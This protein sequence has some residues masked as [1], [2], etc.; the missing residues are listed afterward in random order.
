M[1]SLTLLGYL[2]DQF[3]QSVCNTRTDEYGGSIEN[4]ARFALEV[5]QAV[6]SAIGED[7]TGIRL[8]PWSEFGGKNILAV[9]Y[10]IS[11][12]S[13]LDM[14]EANPI[15]T[16]SY[17]IQQLYDRFPSLAYLHLVEPRIRG[18]NDTKGKEVDAGQEETNE[19]ARAIWKERPLI[20]AGGFDPRTAKEK[21]EKDG[22]LVAF[23]RWY[24]SNVS[25]FDSAFRRPFTS[26]S[27]PDLPE[28]IKRGAELIPYDRKSFYIPESPKGYID[29]PFLE[30]A[31]AKGKL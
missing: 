6:T 22:G 19:F 15:P 20:V 24:I 4:R 11:R 21:V 18:D 26:F 27:Q 5:T 3:T 14:R 1:R 23:G 8:S 13:S 12:W 25:T 7:K 2:I 10:F 29:Y 17:L 31:P 28:R 9:L 16:F 30:D